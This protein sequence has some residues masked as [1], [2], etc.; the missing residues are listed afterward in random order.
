MIVN[1]PVQYEKGTYVGTKIKERTFGN[2]ITSETAFVPDTSSAYHYHANPH[3]SHILAGGSKEIRNGSSDI[4]YAGKGLYYYPGIAHQNVDYRPGTRIFN[5]ELD[6][7]FFNT[8]G[9]SLPPSSL[10]FE[11]SHQLNTGGLIRIMKEHYLD[12][13]DS[14]MA[15]DQLCINLVHPAK[16]GDACFP[17]W[18]KKIKTVMNDYWNQPLSLSLLA[19]HLELHPVTISKHFPRYFGCSAG[20]YMRRMKVERAFPLIKQGKYSLTEI[21]YECGFTDQAHFT[22][23]FRHVTGLLPKQYRNI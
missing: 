3:F 20:E 14:R 12:D 21:A 5:L 23:T 10:M 2:I 13:A 15:I 17:E 9:L 19:A 7:T 11:N 1:K 22:K 16:E 8:F 4:Q 18:T 6:A